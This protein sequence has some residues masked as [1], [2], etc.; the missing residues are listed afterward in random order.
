[1][2]CKNKL[3]RQNIVLFKVKGGSK[4]SYVCPVKNYMKIFYAD[5]ITM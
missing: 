5:V 3:C 4:H 2:N 1:M